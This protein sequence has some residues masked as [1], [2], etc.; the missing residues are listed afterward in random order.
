MPE[1]RP[2]LTPDERATLGKIVTRFPGLAS[3]VHA[4]VRRLIDSVL[5]AGDGAI[6]T[7]SQLDALLQSVVE[8]VVAG[9]GQ[10]RG[11]PP[12]E[13]DELGGVMVLLLARNSVAQA[14][15]GL[16]SRVIGAKQN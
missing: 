9:S 5:P 16:V 12:T 8:R 2:G 14:R 15:P 4:Q 13:S 6:A 3:A 10:L 11:D 1:P 7:E